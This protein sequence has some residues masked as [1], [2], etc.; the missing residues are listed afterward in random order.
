MCAQTALC[1]EV[2]GA[3]AALCARADARRAADG[4]T[5]PGDCGDDE[6]GEHGAY[7]I[8]FVFSIKL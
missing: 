5:A 6:P 2:L 4:G 1:A 3:C 7:P 8:T